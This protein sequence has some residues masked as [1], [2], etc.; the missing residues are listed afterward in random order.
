MCIWPIC[1]IRWLGDAT[2]AGRLRML[3]GAS[4][5]LALA[6]RTFGRQA[7]HAV[8]LQL[9]HPITG[10]MMQWHAP[11]PDDMQSSQPYC[12]KIQRRN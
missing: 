2:Y 6:L 1:V 12:V 3:A 10:E 8:M 5:E 11:I 7:L 9:K 4:E